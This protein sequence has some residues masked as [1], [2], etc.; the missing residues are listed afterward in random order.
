MR[1]ASKSSMKRLVEYI[2]DEKGNEIRVG[3]VRYSNLDVSSPKAAVNLMRATQ[4]KNLKS[5]CDKTYHLMLS[6]PQGENPPI[7]L[8]YEM[9]DKMCNALDFSE[10]QRLSVIHKDTDNLHLHIAINKIHPDTYVATN[11]FNDYLTIDK[12]L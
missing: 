3:E 2:T 5:K 10:H 11:P 1:E 8:I 4:S 9:E 7:D 6:F 12:K